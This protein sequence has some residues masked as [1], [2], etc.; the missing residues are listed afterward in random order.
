MWSIN[1]PM[2]LAY[3]PHTLML[4]LDCLP[5][6]LNLPPEMVQRQQL[7]AAIQLAVGNSSSSKSSSARQ[8]HQETTR[9]E[10]VLLAFQVLAAA[11]QNSE[12]HLV[13]NKG[14]LQL[15]NVLSGLQRVATW[16]QCS[17]F[18]VGLGKHVLYGAVSNDAE[19]HLAAFFDQAFGFHA[20]ASLCTSL[21]ALH[22]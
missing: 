9:D 13:L 11:K 10:R 12:L 6:Q 8:L 18:L 22:C 3:T 21:P 14:P 15:D 2:F 7:L 5:E 20:S 4:L 16:V 17:F 1:W 19:A